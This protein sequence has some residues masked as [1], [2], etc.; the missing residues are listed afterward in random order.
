LHYEKYYHRH[1]SYS[2]HTRYFPPSVT[3]DLCTQ[4]LAYL[5]HRTI[6]HS[7]SALSRLHTSYYHTLS[8][9]S[10]STAHYDHPLIYLLHIFLPTYLPALL[11]RFHL[12]TYLLY[13]A[14]VSLEELFT[15]SG[16]VYLPTGFILG[17]MA[18]R[19]ERHLMDAG[20]GNFA[21]V[22]VLDFL[23]GTSLG[24]NV[25]DDVA[26]EIEE[27]DVVPR[28]KRRIARGGEKVRRV[29]TRVRRV[30][31]RSEPSQDDDE[32]DE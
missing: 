25:V 4:L 14:I 8:S 3:N 5:I 32:D 16:Y 1:H 10:S 23:C 18:R 29:G 20:R 12:L 24:G 15:S 9:L 17:G 19:K 28:V 30:T 2:S 7:P 26:E 6:L 11:F 31:R 22:G 13:L 21:P 27:E